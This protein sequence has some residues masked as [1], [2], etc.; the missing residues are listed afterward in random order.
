[1]NGDMTANTYHKLAQ[2]TSS[3]ILTPMGHLLNGSLGLCGES[4]EFADL[5]KKHCYQGHDLDREHLAKELGDVLWYVV[6]CANALNYDLAD[7]MNMNIEKLKARYPQG[8]DSNMSKNR[9]KGDI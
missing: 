7:I 5:V 1:M 3:K 2:R 4:G 9:A 6:E 8:F